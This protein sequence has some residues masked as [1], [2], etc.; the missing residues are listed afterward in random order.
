MQE[1]FHY[2]ATYSAAYLAGYSHEESLAIAYSAQFVD[3]CSRTL[4]DK[5]NGPKSAATT[6]TSI[7][8]AES[9]G[10]ITTRQDMTRIWASFHFLPGKLDEKYPKR[11]SHR[12]LEKYRMICDP[13]N[14]LVYDTVMLAKRGGLEACG[15]AMHVLA[16]TWAHRYFAGTPSL[17]I[18][19]ATD[20]YE[21]YTEHDEQKERKIS[22]NHNPKSPDDPELRRYTNSLYQ[23]S[24][25]SIMNL[26]HG[27]AGHL[28]D[29][30]FI[31]YRFLP[32]WGEYEYISKDNPTDYYHAFCQLV[33]AMKFL[34]GTYP[35]F[36]TDRYDW[37]GVSPYKDKIMAILEKRQ[38][39]ANEDWKAFGESLSGHEIEDFRLSKYQKEYLE[40]DKDSKD[41]TFL[42]RFFLAALAQKSMVT[43]KIFISK[44]R[45]AG[46][47]IDFDKSGLRGIQDF[48]KL[49]E[50]RNKNIGQEDVISSGQNADDL[51]DTM[52]KKDR[53]I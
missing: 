5:L 25:T 42:G 47:S 48:W 13:N 38:I 26:G 24:E 44:S 10:L 36:E 9:D 17:V 35:Y 34:I 51:P 18:N 39:S 45:L 32:A 12:W 46:F 16:D 41:E 3:C 29:Y 53:R 49:S 15:L 27:R 43:N 23:S 50:I 40:A 4:L 30:S 8:L 28:P 37:A 1:D 20:F 7:E 19:N 31:R 33:Y 6:Q 11:R 52:Q 22:F 21:I 2:Y 14:P